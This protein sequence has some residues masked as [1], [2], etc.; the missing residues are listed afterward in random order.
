M[1][2]GI[3]FAAAAAN[4]VDGIDLG[5]FT[6]SMKAFEQELHMDPAKLGKI[7][8]ICGLLSCISSIFWGSAA[9]RLNRRVLVASSTFAL[10]C[11]TLSVSFIS[12]AWQLCAA[13]AVMSILIA[14]IT[15]ITQSLVSENVKDAS[16]GR[17]F[18]LLAMCG[19]ISGSVSAGLAGFLRWKDAYVIMGS[20]TMLLSV[21]ILRILPREVEN[22]TFLS[23]KAP[24]Q[25]W[26]GMFYSE[27]EK[28]KA[29]FQIP[30]FLSLLFGGI[31]GC[32][33]WNALNFFM[34]YLQTVGFSAK[35]SALLITIMSAGKILGNLFGGAL[36]D[37]MVHRS[38]QHGRAFVAQISIVLGMS[39]LTCLL[40]LAQWNNSPNFILYAMLIFGFGAGS[41][42]CNPGVDRPL[43]AELVGPD[44]R[45]K[46]VAWWTFVAGSFG[47]IFGSML[48]GWLSVAVLGYNP[49]QSIDNADRTS[50]SKALGKALIVCTMVPWALCFLCYSSI[51][52]TYPLDYAKKDRDV[53]EVL[54]PISKCQKL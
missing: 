5:L 7:M 32:I 47:N 12:T 42:W 28:V 3:C 10:G 46:I 13:Q 35:A 22:C 34:M 37:F 54:C 23:S 19:A 24:Q 51:H 8:S 48:V 21:I 53:A 17:Y 15:P 14:S 4:L 26:H 39:T 50:N 33:P 52:I 1:S 27:M 6:A 31:V 2:S 9:D 41:T 44:S 20:A 40:M 36:G 18:A 45:G 16:R 25:S 30:T 11:V 43:W 29:I 49:A 38:P